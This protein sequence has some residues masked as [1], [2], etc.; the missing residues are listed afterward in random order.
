MNSHTQSQN[1]LKNPLLQ[2]Y[3]IKIETEHKF[4]VGTR[5]KRTPNKTNHLPA[6]KRLAS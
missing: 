1:T 4:E 3:S 6:A 5:S 2:P